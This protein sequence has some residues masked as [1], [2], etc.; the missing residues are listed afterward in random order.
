MCTNKPNRLLIHHVFLAEDN[1]ICSEQSVVVQV[2]VS[3]M[4][5]IL[6]KKKH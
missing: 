6:L 3:G 2:G 1:I 5:S 4:E